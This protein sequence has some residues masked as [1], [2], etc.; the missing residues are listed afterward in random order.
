MITSI[1][2][3]TREK[4]HSFEHRIFGG[5]R[6]LTRRLAHL[7]F[8]STLAVFTLILAFSLTACDD[9]PPQK[10][11]VKIG[12]VTNNPNGLRNIDG[13]RE[14]MAEL[15]YIEGKNVTYD[16]SESPVRG[17]KLNATLQKFVDDG[18]DLIFTAGTPTGVAAH[19][20]T[21]GSKIPVV[22][23]VIA[24]PIAAGVLTDLTTPGGNMTGVKLE[25]DQARR[26]DLF[27]QIIPGIKRLV[28]LYNPNDS[29][30][31]SAVAQVEKVVDALNVNLTKLEC[32]N[33]EAV[34]RALEAIPDDADAIFLVPD[35]VVNKRIKDLI[36]FSFENN[37]PVSGP[38]GLQTEKGAF[39]AFG[40]LHH[41][42]GKQAA[43]LASRILSGVKPGE[44][45]VETAESYLALNL[46]TAN[47]LGIE[48][49]D[50]F[51][52]KATLVIRPDTTEPQAQ[53]SD[54]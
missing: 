27:L 35:S 52:R 2:S 44:L 48:I 16:F 46:V 1:N 15:G 25:K 34:T 8:S 50:E 47:K 38:S 14:G 6:A 28:V 31:S 51:L 21:K 10:K 12:L 11:T 18:L 49:P 30:P 33:N 5:A 20:I 4:P 43:R 42:A 23:G 45:P 19:R 32:P 17:E 24:D 36:N 26:L 9:P 22:F 40:F 7:T 54:Q 41:E 29:A 37:L 53:R 3:I 13:F 39:M